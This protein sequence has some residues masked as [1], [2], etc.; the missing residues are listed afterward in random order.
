MVE[1]IYPKQTAGNFDPNNLSGLTYPNL[2]GNDL[3]TPG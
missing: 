3:V 1:S 2:P